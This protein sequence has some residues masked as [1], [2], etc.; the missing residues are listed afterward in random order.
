MVAITDHDHWGMRFLDATP[1]VWADIIAAAARYHDP[2]RFVALPAYEWTNWVS[3]H[4]HVLYFGEPGPVF[5]SLTAGTDTPAGLWEA[6]RPYEAV[7]IAHHSAGGPI[8]IDWSIAPDPELEPVTELCSVH[9]SSEAADSPGLIYDAVDGNFVRD[10]LGRGYR[11]GLLC[12][13]DG[14]DGHPGLAH[15]QA[16]KGGLAGILAAEPTKEAVLEALRARRVYGT[17]GV[18][19]LLRFEVN[20]APMGSEIPVPEGPV[21]AMVRVVATDRVSHIELIR[22]PE[23]V[24]VVRGEW[25]F[26][27]HHRFEL[28]DLQPGEFVYA[29]VRQADGGV[30]WS[31]P[32]FV[33]PVEAQ[34]ASQPEQSSQ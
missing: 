17:N 20:G 12:S 16:G 6:L 32:V 33:G 27:A 28:T 31:S 3:G 29:R 30:A 25:S 23:V 5:G 9:G 11:M 21:E 2:G 4:R 26:A 19:T 7:T 34:R 1:A 24:E 8:P 22:G 14:H 13:T 18:R 10:A 15:L